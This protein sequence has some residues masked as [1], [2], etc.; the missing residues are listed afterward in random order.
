MKIHSIFLILTLICA[1]NSKLEAI[2]IVYDTISVK[3]TC[4]DAFELYFNSFLIGTGN[5]WK[6]TYSYNPQLTLSNNIFALKCKKNYQSPGFIG[7]FGNVVTSPNNWKCKENNNNVNF[8]LNWN[9]YDFDDSSWLPASSY[10][11]NDEYTYWKSMTGEDRPGI[12]KNAEWL[13]SNNREDEIVYCR[14][15][16]TYHDNHKQL[17]N[18]IP[19]IQKNTSIT[20]ES[21]TVTKSSESKTV[22]KS[23]ESKTVTKSSESKTVT[24]SNVDSSEVKFTSI[25]QLI[26]YHNETNVKLRELEEQISKVLKETELKQLEEVKLNEYNYK[27]ANLTLNN[28]MSKESTIMLKIR[29]LHESIIELNRSITGH[30]HQMFD[31]TEYFNKLT[32]IKPKFLGTLNKVNQQLALVKGY[33]TGT[34]IEGIDKQNMLG[35]IFNLQNTTKYATSDLSRAFLEHYEKYKNQ[36]KRNDNVYEKELHKLEEYVKTYTLYK[37]EENDVINEYKRVLIIVNKLKLTYKSSIDEANLFNEL[38]TRILTLLKNNSCNAK[39]FTLPDLDNNCATTLLQSHVQN[40]F[41]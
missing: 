38:I 21:K 18:S 37:S 16:I 2:P 4:D 6:N 29:T 35:L 26:D 39:S 41:I 11:N 22:T 19:L 1:F 20:N 12:P 9:L 28:V 32:L 33:I 5:S 34:I 3:M 10:G 31:E 36:I 14:Y 30:Y 13:W 40:N 17:N 15:K 8:P 23:S 25:N 27:S 7:V 24:K